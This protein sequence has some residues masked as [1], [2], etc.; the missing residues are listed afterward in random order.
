M[1]YV[2]QKLIPNCIRKLQFYSGRALLFVL[3]P[4][5][6]VTVAVNGNFARERIMIYG[7][8]DSAASWSSGWPVNCG[9]HCQK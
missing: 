6:A 1:G 9:I 5:M 8:G 4:T 3:S 2:L 7:R